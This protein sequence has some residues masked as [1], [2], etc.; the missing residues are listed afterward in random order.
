MVYYNNH[1]PQSASGK[2]L[3]TYDVIWLENPYLRWDSHWDIY[4]SMDDAIPARVHWLSIL[5]SLVIVMVL[6]TM[7]AA[8]LVRK[9]RRD[10]PILQRLYSLRQGL[11][12]RRI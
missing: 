3:F 7:I 12:I 11:H 1:Q 8:I 6:S 10:F 2:V 4:L 5:N 9:L